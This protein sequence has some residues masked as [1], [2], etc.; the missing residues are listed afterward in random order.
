[1][2]KYF[3]LRKN[4]VFEKNP[5][6]QPPMY[7]FK[8]ISAYPLMT[9][10][11]PISSWRPHDLHEF[12]KAQIHFQDT[13]I[14]Q[15]VPFFEQ[16]PFS[17]W[18]LT[19]TPLEIWDKTAITPESV[20]LRLRFKEDVTGAP[21]A[22]YKKQKTRARVKRLHIFSQGRGRLI[23]R[24]D[25]QITCQTTGRPSRVLVRHCLLRAWRRTHRAGRDKAKTR[26]RS[27]TRSAPLPPP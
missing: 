8:K 21:R 16:T 27:L 13:N 24:K 2:Y 17:S 3:S 23:I 18:N 22:L 5:T 20:P 11:D 12:K 14:V 4:L 26:P 15:F 6:N 25:I 10:Y 9:M 7:V 19:R 1:M